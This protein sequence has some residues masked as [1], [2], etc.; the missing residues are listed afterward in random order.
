MAEFKQLSEEELALA[1][2]GPAVYANR[3]LI[4]TAPVVRIT[5][6]EQGVGKVG[7][8]FRVA[9]AMPHQ[10]AIEMANLLKAL[11]ADIEADLEK[12]RAEAEEQA[13]PGKQGQA[14]G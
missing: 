14:N 8:S 2:S 4:Q 3:V 12:I 10:T 6:V 13:K 9:V 1:N 11:L 5:F 7:S